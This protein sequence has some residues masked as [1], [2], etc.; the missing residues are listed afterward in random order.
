MRPVA[1]ITGGSS[2]IG[3]AFA[4][5]LAE[6]GHDLILVA[7]RLD[8]LE[9]SAQELERSKRIAVEILAADLTSEEDMARVER[10]ITAANN[11]EVLVNNA[12]FGTLGKFYEADLT[13]QDRMHRLHVLATVR[14]THAALRG[15]VEPGK[16]AL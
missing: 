14:L 4:Q 9:K 13:S 3:A 10:C 8:R 5:Q 2:G 16:A 1:L 12:G 7:R 11:L 6:Q 15:M